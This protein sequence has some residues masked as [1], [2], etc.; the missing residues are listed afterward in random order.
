MKVLHVGHGF[1]PESQGGVESYLRDLLREQGRQGLDVTL[2]TGSMAPWPECGVEEL[3]IEGLRVLRLHRDDAYFDV[4]S[5]AHH[6]VVSAL[7]AELIARER[8]DVVHLH[9]W[10]RLSSDLVE[11]ASGLG[12]PVVVTLHD[13][14]T[15]C[16]RA[17]RVD[18]REQPCT[19]PLSVEACGWCVP[20]YGH[21]DDAEIALGIDLHRDQYQGELALASAVLVASEAT[22]DLIAATTPCPRDRFTIAPLGY[23]RRYDQP[24]PPPPLPAAGE[25]F[26]F[27]YWGSVAPR[28]GGI[29]LLEAMAQL[30]Q[31][32]A[33]RPVELCI[34]G[35]C[36][37]EAFRTALLERAAGLPVRLLGPYDYSGLASAGVHMAVFPIVCFETFGFVLD[38]AH[39]LGLPA[40]VTDHGALPRRAA[41]AS[42]AVPPNDA[43]ALAAAMRSVLEEPGVRDTLA[44]RL[45]ALP[46]TP[47]EHAAAL[48]AI[49]RAPK[50]PAAGGAPV[51]DRRRRG[52]FTVKQRES[53]LRALHP[54]RGPY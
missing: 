22:A 46:P 52:A 51:V 13:L 19:R 21:E 41:G 10:I 30:M 23:R 25:P 54:G 16:P 12:V 14:Y 20:R 6:P 2:L 37:T 44:A 9:Q 39:E 24:L 15:S 34:F 49:Y 5:K 33:P 42:I 18:A 1:F 29:V 48:L 26:R 7:F 43:A 31:Q 50:G 17:F 40:I 36:D 35:K 3:S 27:G 47:A 11:V 4:H 32:G 28:K 8:P 38:E 45:P 53:A